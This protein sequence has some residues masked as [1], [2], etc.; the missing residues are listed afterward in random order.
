MSFSGFSTESMLFLY[1]LIGWR[2]VCRSW[3]CGSCRLCCRMAV[4]RIAKFTCVMSQQMLWGPSTILQM[5]CLSKWNFLVLYISLVRYYLC[6]IACKTLFFWF[7]EPFIVLTAVIGNDSL[8]YFYGIAS[9]LMCINMLQ[10][11]LISMIISNFLILL[12]LT[13]ISVGAKRLNL[14]CVQHF[15]PEAKTK[16]GSVVSTLLLCCK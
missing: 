13:Y 10:W 3:P 1:I 2:R 6:S 12:F 5:L 16:E 8:R 4:A 7:I 9:M 15:S 14:C 11:R